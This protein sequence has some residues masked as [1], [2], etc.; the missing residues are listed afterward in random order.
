MFYTLQIAEIIG[1]KVR[2]LVESHKGKLWMEL[3]VDE[4][5]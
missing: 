1:L 5:L 2:K 4:S 3:K